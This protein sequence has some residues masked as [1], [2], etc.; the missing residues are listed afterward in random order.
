MSKPGRKPTLIDPV[1][2]REF[3]RLKPTLEDTA[4]FFECETRTVQRVIRKQFNLSFKQF[5]DENM[6]H[7]R[8]QLIR[9]AIQMAMAGNTAMLTFSLKN[10]CGWK[11]RPGEDESKVDVTVNNNIAPTDKSETELD[12]RVEELLSKRGRK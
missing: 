8:M 2:L 7:T 10:L 11:D 9:K 12:A 6:V 4:A 1:K 5:R 3:M